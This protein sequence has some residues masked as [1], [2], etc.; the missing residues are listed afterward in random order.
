[1]IRKVCANRKDNWQPWPREAGVLL[2][3]MTWKFLPVPM[4]NTSHPALLDC[5]WHLL[6]FFVNLAC[7]VVFVH[8]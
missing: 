4:E 5:T 6:L 1:M 3:E 2:Q 8:L 7:G